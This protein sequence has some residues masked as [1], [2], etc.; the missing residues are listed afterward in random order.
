MKMTK[1]GNLYYFDGV[2]I[3]FRNFRGAA[4]TYN[5]EGDRNFC[6]FVDDD[7]AEKLSSTGWN[8]RSLRPRDSE[9]EPRKYIRVKV[10]FSRIPPEVFLYEDG[11]RTPLTAETV[12]SIDNIPYTDIS[13]IDV[14]I[15]ASEYGTRHGGPAAYTA[16]LR[17]MAIT[18][19]LDD[20]DRKYKTDDPF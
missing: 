6:M 9:D 8:V 13:N 11:I 14:V 12:G 2:D 15:N 20:F 10:D 7:V 3:L 19:E 5:K 18:V 4:G 17:K 16:Y 1:R